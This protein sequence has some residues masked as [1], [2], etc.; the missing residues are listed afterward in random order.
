M[1]LV[2]RQRLGQRPEVGLPGVV[3]LREALQATLG[4]GRALADHQ[5]LAFARHGYFLDFRGRPSTLLAM[6]SESSPWWMKI[7]P[8]S[9][10]PPRTAQPRPVSGVPSAPS[11]PSQDHSTAG[12][13]PRV[14]RRQSIIPWT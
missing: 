9:S 10:S 8:C 5:L 2:L 1:R 12:Y 7:M 3:L 11:P 14:V 13:S 6:N 4:E